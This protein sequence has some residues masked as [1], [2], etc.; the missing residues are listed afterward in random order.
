MEI[1]NQI[2]AL[3][4][5][6]G[7]RLRKW[8]SNS[9][10]LLDEMQDTSSDNRLLELDKFGSAK[11]LGINWNPAK[12]AFQYRFQAEKSFPKT[13][14]KRI[15]LSQ[16]AQIFDPLGLLGPDL[17]KVNKIEIPLRVT[18]NFT[19]GDTRVEIHGFSDASERAYGACIYLRSFNAHGAV[20][21][22][23]LC[24]KSRVSPIKVLST[25]RLELCGAQ[26]LVHL[27]EK[28]KKS[29]EIPIC[30]EYYWTDSSIVLYWIK[31][32]NK[33]LPVFVAHRVGD[34]Q[35]S[36][37]IED[38]RHVQGKSNPAD[39]ISRGA[40]IQESLESQIW[41]NGPQWL[42]QQHLPEE[43]HKQID[44]DES[45][46]EDRDKSKVV[47]VSACSDTSPFEKY[48]NFNRRI[49]IAATCLRFLYNCKKEKAYGPL[50]ASE[51]ERAEK[52]LM[53]RE[54]EI[55]FYKEINRLK[56][57]K[58]ILQQSCLKYLNPFLDEDQLLRVGGRLRHAQLSSDIKH[59]ILLPYHSRFTEIIIE[60]EHLRSLHAGA[61][62]TWLLFAKNIGRSRRAVQSAD[63]CEVV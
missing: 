29:L 36:T 33:K 46:L 8:A 39:L 18:T 54:Q 12:D 3:L 27:A 28:V 49:R 35:D 2:S 25:P 53:R 41:W 5:A 55:A 32:T 15:V 20:E 10:S 11:T 19:E 47:A 44:Y 50:T 51:L 34:I 42:H 62:A 63:Y 23:L 45:Q 6:G 57:G 4:E 61:D 22:H 43:Q 56:K 16:I 26:L 21:V 59:P 40:S 58:T 14:T 1:R 7:F 37:A 31:A 30:K 9:A 17:L 24:S 52:S 13:Y 60:H 48:S 38:W